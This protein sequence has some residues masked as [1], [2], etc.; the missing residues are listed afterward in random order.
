MAEFNNAESE[1]SGVMAIR[2]IAL[3]LMN[4]NNH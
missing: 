4:E 3:Y 1:Q 2:R